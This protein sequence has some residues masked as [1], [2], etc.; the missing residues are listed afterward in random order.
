METAI[1]L[2]G[3]QNS[4]A[5]HNLKYTKIIGDGDSREIKESMRYGPNCFIEKIECKN[6]IMRNYSYKPYFRK[7]FELC[8]R[9]PDSRVLFC[10]LILFIHLYSNRFYVVLV[11]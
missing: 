1:I 10:I 2:E 7:S 3:F 8:I 9:R 6:H 11:E 4:V 5:M